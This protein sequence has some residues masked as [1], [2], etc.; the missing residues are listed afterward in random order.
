[1]YLMHWPVPFVPVPFEADPR[2]PDGRGFAQE[3]EPDQC[4][5]APLEEDSGNICFCLWKRYPE[6]NACR[7]VLGHEMPGNHELFEAS[8][9]KDC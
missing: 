8:A 7:E 4:S 2:Y 1:M 3:Y 5:K 6:K 9:K